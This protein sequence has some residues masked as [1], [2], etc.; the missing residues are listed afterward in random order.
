MDQ[1]SPGSIPLCATMEPTFIC[2]MLTSMV[3]IKHGGYSMN[4]GV[5]NVQ[6]DQRPGEKGF[7]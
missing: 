2:C 5:F 1:F 4:E 3:S 7:H 6:Q